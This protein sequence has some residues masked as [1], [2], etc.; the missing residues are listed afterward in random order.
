MVVDTFN[1]GIGAAVEQLRKTAAD[2]KQMAAQSRVS[3]SGS[4]KMGRMQY[5]LT[6]QA[7]EDKAKLLEGQAGIIEAMRV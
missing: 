2:Y 4:T 1:T 6:A 3:A 7:H 5:L